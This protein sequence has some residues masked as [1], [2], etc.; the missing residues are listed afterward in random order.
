MHPEFNKLTTEKYKEM[1]EV[2]HLCFTCLL[3][4]FLVL[5]GLWLEQHPWGW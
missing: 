5:P 3:T 4:I 2:L 1:G